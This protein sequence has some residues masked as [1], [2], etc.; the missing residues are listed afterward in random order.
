MKISRLLQVTAAVFFVFSIALALCINALRTSYRDYSEAVSRQAEFKQLGID[1]VDASKYLTDQARRYA[2]FGEKVYYDNYWREVN[3]TKNRDRVVARLKQLNAPQNEL[4]LIEQSKS[5][6]DTLIATEEA[7]MKAVAA[8]KFDEARRLLFDAAYD[9]NV[10]TI[11]EPMSA[12]QT[13]MNDRAAG[14]TKAAENRFERYL[15]VTFAI[16]FVVAAS[17][18]VSV[19]ALYRKIKP[20]GSVGAKLRE[21]AN[22]EGDLTV[23]LPV[24]SR[25]EIGEVAGSFN[26]MLGNYQS[27]IRDI[28]TSAHNVLETTQQI[29]SA[30]KEI[31]GGS[32]SQAKSAERLNDLF[33]ELTAAIESVAKHAD[34]AAGVSG[35]TT[36]VAEQGGQ[37]ILDSIREM[38]R[39]NEQVALLERD[40][41]QIGAIIEVIDDI[42]EQT[43]L[44]ALNA[45]IEAARAG[46]QG[47]GFAVVADEVRK[48]AER[49]GDA[50]KQITDII[51]GMQGNTKMSVNAVLAAVD[52]SEKS[53]EAFRSIVAMV[54]DTSQTVSE[55]AAA[56]EEQAAQS[57]EVLASIES[58]AA[59]S[60]QSAAASDQ[61]ADSTQRLSSMAQELNRMVSAFKV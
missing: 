30:S 8:G 16:V 55:I 31:A 19:W 45:A 36:A 56:T 24:T 61:T 25:D 34:H 11:M 60:E 47:R 5:K 13:K 48:L 21:L 38:N 32:H 58:I 57:N 12:F 20:L 35:Q 54:R 17:M 1:L 15:T 9:A 6:S 53:G 23:R 3:E 28:M 22:N 44:L 52:R 33:R 26:S 18:L 50:T 49:S 40:S 2:Q 42:A 14:E 37:V 10:K 7:A 46:E 59:A 29:S 27:F 41:E 4:D 43:N 51:R 39:L